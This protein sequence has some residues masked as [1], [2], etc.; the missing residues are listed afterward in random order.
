MTAQIPGIYYKHSETDMLCGYALIIGPEISLYDG[1]YDFYKF[2]FP[3]DYPRSP[4]VVELL[5]NDGTTRMHPT[6]IKIGKCA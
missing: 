4:P 6:C 5:T 2:K 1:G 3:P